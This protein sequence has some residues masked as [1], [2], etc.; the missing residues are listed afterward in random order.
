MQ[1]LQPH[2]EQEQRQRQQSARP[3]RRLCQRYLR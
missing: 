3:L 1:A 2:S